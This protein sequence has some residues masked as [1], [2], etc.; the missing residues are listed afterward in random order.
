VISRGVEVAID[1]QMRTTSRDI[2]RLEA[3]VSKLEK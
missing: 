1:M 2:V 3:L